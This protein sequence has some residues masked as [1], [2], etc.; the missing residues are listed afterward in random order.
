MLMG[1]KLECCSGQFGVY[2]KVSLL[3]KAKKYSY[4]NLS[5]GRENENIRASR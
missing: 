4:V 3:E 5:F 1:P 2:Q